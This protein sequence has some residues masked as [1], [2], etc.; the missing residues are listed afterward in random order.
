MQAKTTVGFHPTL[1]RMAIIQ[2]RVKANAGEP[3]LTVA[4]SVT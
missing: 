3:L 1:V 4:G 2:K